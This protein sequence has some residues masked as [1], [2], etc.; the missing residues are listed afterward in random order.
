[1][2]DYYGQQSGHGGYPQGGQVEQADC[3]HKY[4]TGADGAVYCEKCGSV[5][6]D[7][8]AFQSYRPSHQ[9]PA[10]RK[11]FDHWGW[12]ALGAVALVI[13]AATAGWYFVHQRPA[14]VASTDRPEVINL[15]S[16]PV[17]NNLTQDQVIFK[18]EDG[19]YYKPAAYY[20]IWA[21]AIG[22]RAYA[23]Y[24]RGSS[25]FPIDLGL[26][27][28]DV[29]KSDYEKYVSFHFS[30]EYSANQW[31]MFQFK[32]EQP[33]WDSGYFAAHV[34]NNHVCPA[35][36]NIYDALMSLKHDD[37]VIIEGYLAGSYSPTGQPVL[38]SS[39][40]RTD[41]DAGACEAFFVQRLQ[42]GDKVYK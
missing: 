35:S 24:G 1:M 26:T 18:R 28:G 2:D 29:A 42:V 10:T 21:K 4:V 12:V 5:L 34:S 39:L 7:N 16:E 23:G 14:A 15:A 6:R 32:G 41:T 27:W 9:A 25:G 40:S 3:L 33:P 36:E 11:G 38:G 22:V 30:S 8:Y 19:T 20:K 37:E 17:Q 31:L 13:V